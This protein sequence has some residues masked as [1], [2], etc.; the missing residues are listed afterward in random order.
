[1]A[2]RLKE[3]L[4]KDPKKGRILVTDDGGLPITGSLRR[5]DIFKVPHYRFKDPRCMLETGKYCAKT[6]VLYEITCLSCNQKLQKPT[7][8]GLKDSVNHKIM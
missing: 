1:M 2:L 6:D 7:V 8:S 4:N 3:T 5:T